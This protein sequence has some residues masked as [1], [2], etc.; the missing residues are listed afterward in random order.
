ME[1]PNATAKR[2]LFIYQVYVRNHTEAG[3]FNALKAD[4]DRIKSMGVDMIYLLPV[5]PIGQKKRKG[6]LGSPYAIRDYTQINEELGTMSDFK[7]LIDAIHEKKMTVMMDVVFNHTSPDSWLLQH[8]PEFFYQEDG[9]F[10]NRI[11]DWWDVT[12]FD[13]DKGA[14]ALENTLIDVLKQY[15]Q[16]G[17][18]GYRFDVASLLPL[19]FLKKARQAIDALNPNTVWL[20]ESVHG[21]F[22]KEVRDRGFEA[23]SEAE[24]Y[25]VFDMAYDYDAHPA[26]EAYLKNEGP[27]MDYVAWLKRQEEIYPKDYVKMRNL[28]N[29][30]FGRIAKM[31]DQQDDK[32]KQWHAFN[33]FSKG[34]TMIFSGSESFNDHHP[35]L[36]NK[37]TIDFSKPS[38]E[39]WFKRLNT[40]TRGS[41]FREGVYDIDKDVNFDVLIGQY[42]HQQEHI[43]GIFNVSLSKGRVDVPLPD[44]LYTNLINDQV[45]EVN[46]GRVNLTPE[47]MILKHTA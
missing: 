9:V 46:K 40:I 16:M 34:A 10:K 45:V 3:T 6:T 23:H 17:V 43:I 38:H 24:I 1:K 26:F 11:G 22:L 19:S 39:S 27:L 13:F 25:Q 14:Q 12:D 20:S 35:D 30:D 32:L 7:A 4:L 15:T 42:R 2:D 47:A 5:H 8:H 37:D 41:V 31:L 18:D 29:H 44:G 21:H 33:F 28:E 36:F